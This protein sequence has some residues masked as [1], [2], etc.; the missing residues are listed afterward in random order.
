MGP[1]VHG[2][3]SGDDSAISDG[4]AMKEF[5]PSGFFVLR[6][7]LLPV[8][9]FL[10]LSHGLAFSHA[11]RSGSDIAAAASADRKLVRA[12]LHS[13]ADLPEVKEALWLASPDFF[14]TLSLWRKDPESEKGQRL[15]R[16]LYRY[17]ARMASRP[18]PFGLFAGCTLG[19]IGNETRLE[20]GART[21]Y[22]RCTRLDME[23]LCHLADK[24]SSDPALHSRVSFHPNSSLYL[25]AGQYHHTQGYFKD[26]MRAYRLVGTDPT[27][28]L[29]ATLERASSGATPCDLA[30]AL[31]K[32]DPEINGEEAH[33][34]IR[35]LIESQ[36][37]VSDLTPPIT[38]PEP[39]A[40]MLAQF[41]SLHDTSLKRALCSVSERLQ[42][43]DQGGLGNDLQRY[44]EIVS[45][46]ATLP[47]EFKLDHLV[48]VDMMKPAVQVSLGRRLVRSVLDAVEALHSLVPAPGEG[49]LEQFK[50]DFRERYQD[51]EV[52]LL[53]ALDEDVGI[54]FDTKPGHD[55]VPEPLVEDLDFSSSADNDT[56]HATEAEFI[57]L[58]KLEDLA[59]EK[60]SVLELDAG[61]L[62]SL[63]TKN[64]WPLPDA[65]AVLGSMIRR[66]E[67]SE[68][69]PSFC[70]QSVLGPSGAMLLGRFCHADPE[71]AA[72]THQHL[73]AEEAIRAADR[74]IFAEV[75]HLPE[76]RVGNVLYRP[77][78]REYEIPFLANSRAPADRQIALSDLMVTVENDRIILRSQ[79]LGCEVL[80]RLTSAHSY[81]HGRNLKIY[82]F[83][84]MLQTQGISGALAWDWGILEQALFLPRV[85]LNDVILAPA[86][87]R[88]TR[89]M[90]EQL[91]SEHAI[92]RLRKIE[93]WRTARGIPRLVLLAEADHQLLI[94][95]E[96]V[97]SMETLIEYI[98]K[99]DSARLVEMFPSPE[100]LCAFGPEGSFTNEV[101]IPFVRENRVKTSPREWFGKPETPLPGKATPGRSNKAYVHAEPGG[102]GNIGRVFLPGSEWLF[103]KI[104]A[105]PSQLDHLLIEQIAP[106]VGKI[107]TSR[108]AD[109]WFFVRYADPGW[110]LRL[111]FHGEPGN[112][113][114]QVLPQLWK[115]LEQQ[116]EQGRAWRVQLDTYEREIERYGGAAGMQTAERF[117]Q[118]DS[119]FALELLAA[120]SEDLG[121]NLRWRL[122][123]CSA[124]TLLSG[125]DF[126]VAAR[127]ELVNRLEKMQ[128]ANLAVDH[129]HKKQLSGRFRDERPVLEKLLET[130]ANELPQAAR[131]ALQRLSGHLRTIRAKLE[132]LQQTGE[133][134]K[135]IP[136]LAGDYLHMHLNRVFRS[137][138]NAQE[139]VLYDFLGRTYESKL[140]REKQAVE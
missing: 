72:C 67:E 35:Q 58:R 59:E 11:L 36:V 30:S 75:A 31:V 47:A 78:L 140:A 135:T 2:Q 7:P 49:P 117:F 65:F 95:F 23:Y 64:P 6:T 115:C 73:Q 118:L 93:R 16:S 121:G 52:P 127:R 122:A 60:K 96:N 138:A 105:S 94:D 46:M 129:K 74:V 66:P 85:V 13:L 133:L 90:I 51:Q 40:D 55:A 86:R 88:M 82:K 123:F 19:K 27:P 128:E 136:E 106:L 124:D 21:S 125:L 28:Y 57:L 15:E 100:Q 114:A 45:S 120:M 48:Q 119:E 77:H 89:E 18:T 79:R 139:M 134:K 12:R 61:L 9:D 84:C 56:F 99:R 83:I 130:S 50:K 68:D 34:F 4:P 71:L 8:Q 3:Y 38:G 81:A 111:R 92:E 103:A 37:L 29:A 5:S 14:T 107:M 91:A 104:Y 102:S 62:K 53:L 131:S 109:A 32:D 69:R 42:E 70:L 20:I 101:V 110:H 108:E 80:P 39:V 116:R 76:G 43:L 137:A 10:A 26:G 63:R 112:L 44:Q 54:G 33:H 1:H 41:E 132:A 25:A 126:N 98:S 113:S 24:I 17:V 97:L 22:S 87:W